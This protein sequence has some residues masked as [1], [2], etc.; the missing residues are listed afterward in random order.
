MVSAVLQQ[1]F[2]CNRNTD[3]CM[4]HFCHCLRLVHLHLEIIRLSSKIIYM[5]R[6]CCCMPDRYSPLVLI[7]ILILLILLEHH[8]WLQ[9]Y[10]NF[11]SN[12]S[13]THWS[14]AL[15]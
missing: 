10:H 15:I 13:L 6:G 12:Q 2:L 1:Y 8:Y 9:E 14:S 3:E 7:A 5:S 4:Q 11:A